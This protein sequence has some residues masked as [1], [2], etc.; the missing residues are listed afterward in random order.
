MSTAVTISS[1]EG[2]RATPQRCASQRSR[3]VI[4]LRSTTGVT[5]RAT[6]PDDRERIVQAFRG[7]DPRSLYLRFLF[8]KKELSG[9]ELHRLCDPDR[10]REVVRV[11]TIGRGNQETIIGL[12]RYVRSGASAEIAFTV[13][14]DYQCRG[15]ASRLL[16]HLAHIARENGI[17]QFEADVL[18][19]NTPMLNVFR[20]GGLPL[21]ESEM[22]DIVHVTLDLAMLAYPTKK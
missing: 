22:D 8:P 17:E 18:A 21:T 14:E 7:L 16:Q 3:D 5:I 15:I 12:G 4:Q 20:H 6:R 1:V 19:E 11:A 2:R 9:E 10:A 13:V